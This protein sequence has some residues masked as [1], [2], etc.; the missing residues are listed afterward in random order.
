ML[1]FCGNC[2]MSQKSSTCHIQWSF[3]PYIQNCAKPKLKLHLHVYGEQV[4]NKLFAMYGI[5]ET[6]EDEML[7]SLLDIDTANLRFDTQSNNVIDID[8]VLV[9]IPY[10]FGSMIFVLA[11]LAGILLCSPSNSSKN[12]SPLQ[13]ACG[14]MATINTFTNRWRQEAFSYAKGCPKS[15]N[16]TSPVIPQRDKPASW[17]R[18]SHEKGYWQQRHAGHF[19]CQIRLQ[20]HYGHH[21]DT[22][23]VLP[24]QTLS[25][26]FA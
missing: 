24:R 7:E 15:S 5:H 17:S 26:K 22:K 19:H 6:S 2:K 14:T 3:R 1:S 20:K 18:R 9:R 4:M 25:Q 8:P 21:A 11:P 10:K 23:R 12:S 16:T 13:L